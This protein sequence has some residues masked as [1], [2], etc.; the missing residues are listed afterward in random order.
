MLNN[1]LSS[2]FLGFEGFFGFVGFVGVLVTIVSAFLLLCHIDSHNW[3]SYSLK[4]FQVL[5]RCIS[6]NCHESSQELLLQKLSKLL[7]PQPKSG[8]QFKTK[9]QETSKLLAPHVLLFTFYFHDTITDLNKFNNRE[10]KTVSSETGKPSSK[11][12]IIYSRSTTSI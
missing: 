7:P 1:A 12:R 8:T 10:Q 5:T 9:L 3:T 4:I 11:T 2:W 6:Q